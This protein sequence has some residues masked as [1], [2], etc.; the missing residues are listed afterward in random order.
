MENSSKKVPVIVLCSGG[1]DSVTAL[2][3]AVATFDVLAVLSFEYGS[4]HNDKEIP[5]AAHHA[6]KLGL[7]HHVIPLDFVRNH[8]ASHLLKSGAQ[9]PDGHYED[10]NMKQTVVP[11]RNG[12]MLSLACGFAESCGAQGVVIAA[13]AGDHA[14]YPDCRAD[15]MDAMAQAMEL[16]TYAGIKLLRPFIHMTKANIALLGEELE[17]DWTK[18]WSCYKGGDVHCG[19]C[20]TCT[21]RREAFMLAGVTDPTEYT[22]TGPL[23]ERKG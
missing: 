9:V 22:Y 3:Y 10:S 21:E 11:F 8:F 20:G 17:I 1:M 7:I 19:Q 12:I 16:G 6:H 13:H 18:T 5:M 23:A 14:I 4:K 2:Y 15:Y